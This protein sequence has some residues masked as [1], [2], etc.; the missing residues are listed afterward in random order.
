[1]R[2]TIMTTLLVFGI[3]LANQASAKIYQCT[4]D[5]TT[6]F[7]D[8]PCSADEDMELRNTSSN[9][10]L[11]ACYRVTERHGRRYQIRDFWTS[12][13]QAQSMVYFVEHGQH[14]AIS[15][16]SIH[17]IA[18]TTKQGNCATGELVRTN[19]QRTSV[20]F[21]NVINVLSEHGTTKLAPTDITSITACS[22]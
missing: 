19:D 15:S 21:C 18:L 1:M 9:N 2:H 5:G 20:R 7:Q 22:K 11:R 16:T 4:V 12:K 13:Q 10:S 3:I 17:S 14:T 6:Q 8:K